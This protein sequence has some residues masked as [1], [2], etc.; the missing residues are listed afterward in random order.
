MVLLT[1]QA[2]QPGQPFLP[3]LMEKEISR[4]GPEG[5]VGILD[6]LGGKIPFANPEI[7]WAEKGRL[8]TLYTDVQL[9][10]AST[11]VFTK[12]GHIFRIGQTLHLEDTAGVE[13]KGVITA[14][15]HST[16]TVARYDAANFSTGFATTA[17]YKS[18]CIRF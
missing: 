15:T 14:I 10:G 2:P 17:R 13:A 6:R 9:T 16:F 11:G 1:Q 18:S 12:A 4:F 3:E 5:L 7:K 8:H